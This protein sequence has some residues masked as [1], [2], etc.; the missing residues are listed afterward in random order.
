MAA[1]P[2]HAHALATAQAQ[3][4]VVSQCRLEPDATLEWADAAVASAEARGFRYRAVM[5]RILRGWALAAQGRTDAG[6]DELRGGLELSRTTGARM[7]DP[8]YLGLLADACA[9]AGRHEEA[10]AALDEALELVLGS[11]T[12]FYE[13]ELHRLRGDVL[14]GV[15]RRDDGEASLERALEVAQ[16][17]GSPALELRAAVTL[18]RLRREQGREAEAARLVASAYAKLTEGFDTPDLVQGRALLEELEAAPPVLGERPEPL[19]P[20][21]PPRPGPTRPP[22]RYARSGDLN[23][24]YQVTG[25]GPVDVVLVPGFVSH[26]EKDWEEPRHARFLDRLGSFSRLIRF[27]KRGTGLSDP[28]GGLPDLEARMDDVRAV[29]DAAG[30][31]RAV[32]LGYSEGGPMSILLAATYPE[33]ASSLVLYGSF[34]A[35]LRSDDYPWAP[36]EAE[37]QAYAEEIERDW[38]FEAMMRKMCPS[39]DEA[40]ARWWGERCRAAASPG[41]ARALVEMNTRIDVRDVLPAIHVPTLVLHRRGDVDVRVEEGRYLAERIPGAR[42]VELP[43]ADHFVAVDPDQIVDEV[44]EFVTGA[45][46]LLETDRVLKTILV[47]DLVDSTETAARLGDRAWAELLEAHHRTVRDV[48]ARFAGEEVD[49]AGDGVLALFD[50]PARAIRAGLDLRGRLA[51]LGLPVR[52][53]IH[54]GEVHRVGGTARGIAVHVAARVAG[55]AAPAEVLVTATTRDLVAGSDLAFQDRGERR[56]KGFEEPRRLFEAVA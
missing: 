51:Q 3:A 2:R 18:G 34:A 12:F 47:S 4:A 16:R 21:S 19:P 29:M 48:L 1:D 31:E 46:P 35:R 5:G 11:R 25:E 10:L 54:T 9:P 14:L 40:M 42:F 15:G 6:I 23:I 45:R 53:G 37:R 33:R 24:A 32:L 36:T 44:E 43:G 56:L 38:G 20:R 22:V 41:A 39:A 26:L 30:S 55:E 49:M 28:L 52:V 13:A 27:D 8:Y 7:D 17:Q 50:G